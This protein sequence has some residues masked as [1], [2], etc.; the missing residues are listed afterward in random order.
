MKD[1]EGR[2][3]FITGGASGA[4]LGQAQVFGRAG[5]RI[6]IADVRQDALDEAVTLLQAEGID[7]LGV[8][9]DITDRTAYAAAADAVEAHF[10]DPVTLLFNTAGVNGFGPLVAATHADFDWVLGVNFGGVVN[11]MLTF[12][13]RMIEAGRGGH[14]VTVSSMAGFTG[15]PSAAVYAAGKAAVINLM[16]SY[17]IALPEHGI[18]VSLLCPASIRSNIANA[19]QTRPGTLAEGSSFSDDPDFIALQAR[20]YA[21]GMDPIRLAEHVRDAIEADRF[22]VLPFTETRDGLRAHFAGIIAAY[23]DAET[24]PGSAAERAAAFDEYRRDYRRLA[25][26]D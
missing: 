10:G 21:G 11:G 9:L 12:V 26:R 19:L 20:L 4:G 13:P 14:I 24:D 25:R 1:F 5:A 15:S 2:V 18:G 8:R 7:T 16:E 3:A 17:A 22:W 6:A 23:D